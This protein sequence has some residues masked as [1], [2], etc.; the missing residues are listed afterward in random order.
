M[1]ECQR[2]IKNLKIDFKS[3]CKWLLSVALMNKNSFASRKSSITVRRIFIFERRKNRIFLWL[4]PFLSVKFYT[5]ESI[6]A[7]VRKMSVAIVV[8]PTM[9]ACLYAI[10]SPMTDT[11]SHQT[12]V[13]WSREEKNKVMNH[14]KKVN[15]VGSFLAWM[16]V[17]DF[18]YTILSIVCTRK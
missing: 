14:S 1:N 18:V 2:N 17:V 16:C 9:F 8:L 15:T 11:N 7:I 3:Q 13:A 4:F 10:Q 6:Y 12:L 5:C